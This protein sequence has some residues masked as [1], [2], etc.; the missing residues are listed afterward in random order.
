MGCEQA[1]NIFSACRPSSDAN[2]A[3]GIWVGAGDM[4][5]MAGTHLAWVRVYA[6]SPLWCAKVLFALM[7]L[8]V[9]ALPASAQKMYVV[10]TVT[11]PETAEL[12]QA[13]EVACS[14]CG[15]I[16]YRQ[17]DGSM[18]K[19]NAIVSELQTEEKEGRLSLVLTL[20]KPATMLAAKGLTDTPIIYTMV[21]RAFPSLEG[22][23]NITAL[24][25]DAPVSLQM[26]VVEQLFPAAGAVGVLMGPED[27]LGGMDALEIPTGVSL[28]TYV[29]SGTRD[30]P[31]AM[32]TAARENDG[33]ILLR[34]RSVVN[35]DTFRFI[36]R[37]SLENRTFTV[38][39][40]KS[41][42][43]MGLTATLIPDLEALG[44]RVATVSYQVMRGEEVRLPALTLADYKIHTNSRVIQ[45]VR[46]V[47]QSD[48]S[49][50]S[51]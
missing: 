15:E 19:G 14:S 37:H 27:T 45:D 28:R 31:D 29:V 41:L 11:R 44:A 32:R 10:D 51:R 3:N 16:V 35:N 40:S 43:D 36:V 13:L 12:L 39:Y 25:T 5:P 22:Q 48:S 47:P 17:M 4:T 2:A 24:P 34:S 21:G 20:G 18:R 49:N 6:R 42:V 33:I 50:D 38:G 1:S 30:V 23:A 8:L 9:S 26:A 46:P 7:L